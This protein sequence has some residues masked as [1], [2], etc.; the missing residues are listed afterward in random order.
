[1]IESKNV[2]Q[3]STQ[4]TFVVADDMAYPLF[5]MRAVRSRRARSW[6]AA[7]PPVGLDHWSAH[8]DTTTAYS[9]SAWARTSE[10]AARYIA[11]RLGL[12][13]EHMARGRRYTLAVPR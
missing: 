6:Y 2:R 9:F 3:I 4:D 1:M 7:L 5:F 8:S 13:I 12:S 11:D 10:G